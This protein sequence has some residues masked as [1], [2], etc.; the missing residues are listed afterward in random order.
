MHEYVSEPKVAVGCFI[1]PDLKQSAIALAFQ[2][3]VTLSE[4]IRGS[5]A[6]Y[7][8]RHAECEPAPVA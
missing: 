3:G 6:E 2:Q 8:E 1:D 7:V 5:L 4:V